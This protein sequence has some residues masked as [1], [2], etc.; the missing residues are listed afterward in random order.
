MVGVILDITNCMRA[1]EA[2]RESG[3]N[4]RYLV[5]N[6]S[7]VIYTMDSQ[8]VFTYVSPIIEKL[9]GYTANEVVG[10][11]FSRFIHPED[12]P[13]LVAS[14]QRFLQGEIEPYEFRLV[15]KAGDVRYVR[16]SCRLLLKDN[17]RLGLSGVINDITERK[18]AEEALRN[19]DHL[20]QGVAFATNIL[21]IKTDLNSAINQAL[22]LLGSA[23]EVDRI[24]VFKNH[25]SETG[26]QLARL[27]HEWVKDEVMSRMEKH[28]MQNIKMQS[29]TSQNITLEGFNY[30]PALSRWYEALSAE[31]MIK[32][33]TAEFPES[34]RAMLESRQVK[35]LL[36]IP[37]MI[38]SRFWGFVGFED[39]HCQRI[40]TDADVSILHSSVASIGGA[41]VRK[42]AEEELREAK[43]AAEASAL[44]KSQFM[45]NMS[46]ELCTPMNAII[47]MTSLLLDEELAPDQRK[48]IETIM[49]SGQDLMFLINGILDFTKMDEGRVELESQPFE[50][51]RCIEAT[52]D[53]RASAA[54]EKGL[55]LSCTFDW[56]V[57]DIPEIIMGDPT[58]LRQ[59]L[60]NL[61]DNAIKFTDKG[62]VLVFVS[63]KEAGDYCQIHFAVKDTGIGIPQ[64]QMHK[65][66]CPSARWTAPVRPNMKAR[67]WAWP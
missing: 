52:L 10:Q 1:E 48:S 38:E 9:S 50:I 35:S 31:R 21:L 43:D 55:E 47:G 2:L 36:V 39:C 24:Y 54:S 4:Y 44:A 6:L 65:L 45:A 51:R 53:L 46:H 56:Y 37:I 49:S 11:Y 8:G 16:T 62:Y 15:H 28:D 30:H 66:F 59:V 7:E 32:G 5:E 67:V 57:G 23:A 14:F 13:G 64:D 3:E 17:R 20:L 12:L 41:I 34:E 26:E 29:I 19:K 22:V 18:H 42:Q 27:Y 58:R 63:A 60:G 61:L 33:L 40:W 25:Q